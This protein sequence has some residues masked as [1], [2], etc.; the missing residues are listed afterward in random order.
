MQAIGHGVSDT[1]GGLAS[2]VRGQSAA[3]HLSDSH[4]SA[5][6]EADFI[7]RPSPLELC[8]RRE[9]I[10]RDLKFYT[11]R[12]EGLIADCDASGNVWQSIKMDYRKPPLGL[13]LIEVTDDAIFRDEEKVGSDG[14]T[15]V[16]AVFKSGP[17]DVVQGFR[18]VLPCSTLAVKPDMEAS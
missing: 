18:V 3:A 7:A 2:F 12:I 17:Y 14:K 9:I 13:W 16:T 15:T 8:V 10:T 5:L 11:S 1:K 4:S 6:P